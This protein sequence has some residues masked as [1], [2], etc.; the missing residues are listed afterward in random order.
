MSINTKNLSAKTPDTSSKRDKIKALI[1]HHKPTFLK[2]G[3]SNP[4][5]IPKLAYK[6]NNV[7]SIGVYPREIYGGKDIY[8]EF[9]DRAYTPENPERTLYKWE[10]DPEFDTNYEKSE[11]HPATKD[12]RYLIPVTDLINLTVLYQGSKPDEPSKLSKKPEPAPKLI[13]EKAKEEASFDF[14]A[15]LVNEGAGSDVPYS[16]MSLRDFAAITWKKP[17]SQKKWLN[18]LIIKQFQI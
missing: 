8:I 2:E 13:P 15:V 11:P 17:V 18:E 12:R 3:V 4:K 5:F 6:H 9:C 14:D 7:L 10:Y 1:E 16:A